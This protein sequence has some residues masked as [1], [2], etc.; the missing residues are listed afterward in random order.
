MFRTLPST[1][2]SFVIKA[3]DSRFLEPRFMTLYNDYDYDDFDKEVAYDQN[4]TIISN[5][6]KI[7]DKPYTL[8][9]SRTPNLKKKNQYFLTYIQT[10]LHNDNIEFVNLHNEYVGDN[11][12]QAVFTYLDQL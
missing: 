5:Q 9:L 7:Q 8:I 10:D 2:G 12:E 11:Y 1:G 3:L 6:I 4:G